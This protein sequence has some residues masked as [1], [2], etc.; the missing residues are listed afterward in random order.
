[1][2]FSIFPPK[3]WAAIKR[4][5]AISE[6]LA[7]RF[8]G[9]LCPIDLNISSKNTYIAMVFVTIE[10]VLLLLCVDNTKVGD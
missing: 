7:L 6:S 5:V 9:S 10:S 3:Y 8:I 2:A 4:V 1:M